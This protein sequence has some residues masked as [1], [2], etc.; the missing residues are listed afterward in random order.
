MQQ[1]LH[2]FTDIRYVFI[3]AGLVS[4]LNLV[5]CVL[6]ARTAPRQAIPVF[7]PSLWRNSPY[8]LPYWRVI[9]R[10]VNWGMHHPIMLYSLIMLVWFAPLLY[11]HQVILPFRP[12]IYA[13]LEPITQSTYIE[14]TFFADYLTGFI[15]Q[16]DLQLHA[17]RSGWLTLWSN[18]LEF[19]HQLLHL[20][21]F[22]PAYVLTWL[23]MWVIDDA[24]VFSTVSFV[25]CVYLTGIFVL[26]Y[27]QLLT[28][29]RSVALLTA[30]C[31]AFTLSFYFYN[32]F[33]MF[34][35]ICCWGTAV[36]YGL[37][38][39]RNQPHNRWVALFISFAIY[40]LLY[41]TY[42]QSVLSAAYIIAGYM[43]VLAWQLRHQPLQFRAFVG[44]GIGAL[45]FGAL[46]TLPTYLD[47]YTRLRLSPA[48]T[49]IGVDFFLA[50]IPNV[51]SLQ[52][53]L[54][55]GLAYVVSDIWQPIT[56]FTKPKY[57]FNGGHTSLL[58]MLFVILG[59]L[60]HWRNLWGWVVWLFVAIAFSFNHMFFQI[61][62][63]SIFPQISRGAFFGGFTHFL[64]Q[65]VLALYGI[66]S[67]LTTQWVQRPRRN[68]LSLFVAGQ[69]VIGAVAYGYW[70]QIPIQWN[71]VGFELGIV[72]AIMVVLRD[73]QPTRKF[74]LLVIIILVN[75]YFLARPLL[76]VQPY[77]NVIHR[78]DTAQTIQKT[79]YPDSYVAVVAIKP[80]NR[81]EPNFTVM[82]DIPIIGSYSS[83]QSQYYLE[84]MR[85]LHVDTST[86]NRNIRSIGLP[87]N[88]TDLWLSNVRTIVSDKPID[89]P[90]ITRLTRSLGMYVYTIADGMGCCLQM[91]MQALR[92][93]N[94]RYWIDN[95]Q[96]ATN[97]R[98]SKQNDQGDA[99][100][101]I[102]T[103]SATDTV[104][105]FNQQF[106]PDWVAQVQ[107]P[108]GWQATTTVVINDVYQ[109]VRIPAGSTTLTMQFKPWIRWSI[110]ANL[111]WI[112]VGV[113]WVIGIVTHK[114][115]RIIPSQIKS[116]L[117]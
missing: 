78:S 93:D 106:H 56:T 23:M 35:A 62:Y 57:P 95:P 84:F 61:G 86:Y 43:A 7:A 88:M 52:H 15:P 48:R 32:T 10:C 18:Q 60:H 87:L 66:H 63:A 20:S 5:G 113:I 47:T 111:F 14:S 82:L 29:H 117:L 100:T 116:K 76:L 81:L 68:A 41:T 101:V 33:V 94:D 27:T 8:I 72:A 34:I 80:S 9:Q 36:C 83:F 98:L 104:V 73:T 77:A 3:A 6:L 28:Q 55:V 75:A 102:V 65:F 11:N 53:A 92:A 69:F 89:T 39:L 54:Q 58:M 91:P 19:G 26:L 1:L 114:Y 24:Y 103:A 70:Q 67:I 45:M 85:R 38:R 25:V 99:F 110:V 4:I 108:Q 50:I 79:L 40:S 13:N 115:P 49:G 96:A 71:F 30:L 12:F 17:N 37:L 112:V 22:S 51:Q 44:W 42:P 46:L 21:G 16:I 109:G 64:P 31:S 97:Q 2:L 59:V 105:M 90:E 74:A 107:T